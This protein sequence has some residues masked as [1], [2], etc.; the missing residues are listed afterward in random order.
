MQTQTTK[1]L[2]SELSADQMSAMRT[3][4]AAERTLMAWVRTSLS[5]LSFGFS[6]YKV[7]QALLIEESDLDPDAPRRIGLF[8]AGAGTIAMMLGA[9]EFW[10]MLRRLRAFQYLAYPMPTITVAIV[11]SAAGVALFISIA[12]SAV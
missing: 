11:M 2:T 5:L 12:T 8:L 4:M 10:Q 6:I 1:D 3:L 9:L 7:M